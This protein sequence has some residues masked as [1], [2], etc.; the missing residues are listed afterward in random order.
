MP[1]PLFTGNVIA[2]VWDF[3]QTL[4]PGYQQGPLFEEYG[5][6]ANKFW[7]ENNALP[8]YY[9]KHEGIAVS[10]DTLYLNHL[11]TYVEAGVLKGLTNAKLKELGSRL[12]FYEGIP[13]F[14]P[15]SK[16][17]IEEQ[18]RFRDHGITV[19]HYILST[20]LRQMILGSAVA[21]F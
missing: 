3:D 13:A 8:A 19:E 15:L 14:L 20:G 5:I 6:D 7:A 11:L 2:V 1:V 17:R 16:Q 10:A 9:A 12:T 4:I 18:P 21:L